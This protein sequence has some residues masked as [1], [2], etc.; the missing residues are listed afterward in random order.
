VE[1]WI[2]TEEELITA[3]E[4]SLYCCVAEAHI[5]MLGPDFLL[6]LQVGL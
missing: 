2:S 5:V 6:L 4:F 1:G 3:Q